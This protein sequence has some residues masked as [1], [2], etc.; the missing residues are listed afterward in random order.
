MSDLHKKFGF[1]GLDDHDDENPPTYILVV[2][3]IM[4]LL[5]LAATLLCWPWML[6]R[7]RRLSPNCRR[8]AELTHTLRVGLIEGGVALAFLLEIALID[9]WSFLTFACVFCVLNMTYGFERLND[10]AILVT[11]L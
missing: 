7:A 9:G 11:W 10:E 4:F 3:L 6:N 8:F 5:V 1:R 2:I